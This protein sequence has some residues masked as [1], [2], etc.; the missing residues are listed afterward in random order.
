MLIRDTVASSIALPV[1]IAA[2][3][4]FPPEDDRVG[5]KQYRGAF[6]IL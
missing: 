2:N 3:D 5:G 4:T 6:A 1:M